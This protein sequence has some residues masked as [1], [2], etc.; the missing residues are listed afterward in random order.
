MPR[1][2]L[3]ALF[4][5]PHIH[6]LDGTADLPD[7]LIVGVAPGGD[8]AIWAAGP[9]GT[10]N[11]GLW[12]AQTI[13]LSM[14]EMVG[15]TEMTHDEFA[16]MLLEENLSEE[17]RKTLATV[18]P[19]PGLWRARAQRFNWVPEVVEATGRA[20]RLAS[21]NG[22]ILWLPA[23]PVATLRA[24]PERL[25]VHWHS[26]VGARVAE[27]VFDPAESLAAFQ[28]LTPGQPDQALRLQLEIDPAQSNVTATLTD[29]QRRHRFQRL[30]VAIYSAE[31]TPAP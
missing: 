5:T 31:Q 10:M 6:P 25:D 27:L 8:V 28:S 16:E 2:H 7:R 3:A 17:A 18:G 1:E 26:A 23:N 29:G 12:Q 14:A 13:E 22:E 30:S 20:F 9:G 15:E 11:I 4:T 21:L 24:A 19:K